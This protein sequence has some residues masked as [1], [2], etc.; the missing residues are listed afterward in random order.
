MPI[1]TLRHAANHLPDIVRRAEAGEEILLQRGTKV[2][3]KIVAIPQTRVGKRKF[4]R[5]KGL[6]RVEPEFFEA[7]P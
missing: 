7:F 4:G 6:V 2:V 5:L 1:F 3:A